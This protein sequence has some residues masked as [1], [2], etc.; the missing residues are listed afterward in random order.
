[1]VSETQDKFSH[2]KAQIE[3]RYLYQWIVKSGENQRKESF[4]KEINFHLKKI[5][6]YKNVAFRLT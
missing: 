6:I 2:E 5:Y 3:I 4:E 1:M